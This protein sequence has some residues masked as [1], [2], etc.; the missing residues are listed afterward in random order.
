ML[1]EE[2]IALLLNLKLLAKLQVML[3]LLQNI[4]RLSFFGQRNSGTII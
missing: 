4:Q 1:T 2:K 3:A